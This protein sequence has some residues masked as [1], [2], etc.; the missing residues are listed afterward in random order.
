MEKKK[1]LENTHT[2][3]ACIYFRDTLTCKLSLSCM[4]FP[5]IVGVFLFGFLVFLQHLPTINI[6]TSHFIIVT[7]FVT[8]LHYSMSTLSFTIFFLLFYPK[9][10]SSIGKTATTLWFTTK[11][12]TFV[13]GCTRQADFCLR[14]RL[15]SRFRGS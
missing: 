15:N 6:F 12:A 8:I 9:I 7:K 2:Q 11:G 14:G 1:G 10:P 5:D 4:Y 13:S 3:C